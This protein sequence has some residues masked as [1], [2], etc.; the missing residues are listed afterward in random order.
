MSRRVPEQDYEKTLTF[1]FRRWLSGSKDP[2]LDT[3]E[4]KPPQQFLESEETIHEHELQHQRIVEH[5]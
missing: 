2:F 3:V 5:S 1:R 4:M